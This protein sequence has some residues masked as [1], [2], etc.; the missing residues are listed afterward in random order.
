M[1]AA[2]S[3]CGVYRLDPNNTFD[4]MMDENERRGNHV[5]FYVIAGRSE[6]P[7]DGYYDLGE[8]RIRALLGRIGRRGHHIGLHASYATCRDPERLRLQVGA[9]RDVL[10][11]VGCPPSEIGNRQHYLRWDP[12]ETLAALAA[13]GV[14]HDSTL[15]FAERIGFRRG[16]SHSFLL[17]DLRRRCVLP[18][19]EWPL[20]AMDTTLFS[21]DYMGL[22]S[23]RAA[24]AAVHPL[25]RR[26]VQYGGCFT[27][28]FHNDGFESAAVREAYLGLLQLAQAEGL[29]AGA[30]S[31][32][33]V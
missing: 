22:T 15:G 19:R 20:L 13:A 24:V 28:L 17:Y 33:P 29:S 14:A 25:I 11:A 1:N 7:I 5:T 16:T 27:M 3:T 32:R 18:V 10:A 26:V 23:A 31:A 12:L 4:W 9:L 30:P 8:P 6:H 21:D 2:A